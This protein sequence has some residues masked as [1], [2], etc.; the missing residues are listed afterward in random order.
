MKYRFA[1]DEATEKPKKSRVEFDAVDDAAAYQFVVR[2][3]I[4]VPGNFPLKM[5]TL[6]R[7]ESDSWKHL[8]IWRRGPGWSFP[9]IR[10]G[11]GPTE[12]IDERIAPG[13]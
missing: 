3:I 2:E 11:D 6:Y 10:R 5:G 13:A 1:I 7:Q 4:D 12:M 8:M 9:T